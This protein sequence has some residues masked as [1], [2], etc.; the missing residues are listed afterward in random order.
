MTSNETALEV[1]NALEVF[2]YQGKQIRTVEQNGE[3]WFIAKDVCNI[4]D[5]TIEA[6]RRLDK[7]E[8]GLTKI[9][10]LGGIQNITII[11]EPGLYK[12][13]F[14]SQKHEAKEF[15][16]W[17][18]HELLPQIRRKG[19]YAVEQVQS[20]INALMQENAELKDKLERV[21]ATSNLGSVMIAQGGSITLF[22]AAH[23]MSQKGIPIGGIRL[24]KFCRELNLL[25][26]RKGRQYNQPTQTAI[27]KGLMNA[28]VCGGFKPIAMI[29]PKGLEYLT[30]LLMK[31]HLPVLFLIDQDERNLALVQEA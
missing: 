1:N 19:Y 17:V 5:M 16:R 11:T 20:Q 29:T 13:I 14:K 27:S 24:Y 7:D 21:R 15:T 23:F 30:D 9:Q 10:T 28:E 6:T 26:K 12:L 25:C 31:E 4:L 18:T 3:S 2:S 22:D 8:K